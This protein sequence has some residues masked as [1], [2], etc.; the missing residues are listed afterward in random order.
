MGG[1]ARLVGETDM[2][3]SACPTEHQLRALALGNLPEAELQQVAEHLE[4]CSRCEKRA[5]QFDTSVDPILAAIQGTATF[6]SNPTRKMVAPATAPPATP[7]PTS[8]PFLLPAVQPDEIG[9][10]G[11]YRV[12][13]L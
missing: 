4:R 5:Q 3:S 1:S 8:F 9:R 11:N 6:S 12:L 13:R 7:S 2:A 10:L